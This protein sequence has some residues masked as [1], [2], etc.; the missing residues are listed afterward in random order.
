MIV[1]NINT[2]TYPPDLRLIM[3]KIFQSKQ[4]AAVLPL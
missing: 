2:F 3:V 4:A 1:M